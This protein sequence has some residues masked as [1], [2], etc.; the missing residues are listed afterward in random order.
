MK[1]LQISQP[2]DRGTWTIELK[3]DV[4]TYRLNVDSESLVSAS[5]LALSVIEQFIDK[6]LPLELV[7]PQAQRAELAH[8]PDVTFRA[9]ADEV[10][11]TE[12]QRVRQGVL[13]AE[14]LRITENR[15][16]R[17]LKPALGDLPITKVPIPLLLELQ[18][19]LAAKYSTVTVHQYFVIVR[20]VFKRAVELGYT[21]EPPKL[22]EVEVKGGV[23]SPFSAG[24]YSLL[25]RRSKAMIG[26]RH[27]EATPE[28]VKQRGIRHEHLVFMPDTYAAI[29]LMVNSFLRPGDLRTLK[30][31]HVTIARQKD[32]VYLRLTLPPPPKAT[33][34]VVAGAGGEGLTMA[35]TPAKSWSR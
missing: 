6:S 35:Q 9:V 7:S 1:V 12:A 14:S 32:S 22:P 33:L 31:K 24:E 30:H 27:P 18:K 16:D 5:Q 23:R 34:P 17:V 2:D 21:T 8:H 3:T 13:S 25:M 26:A 11:S 20:K 4:K 19:S 28:L 15:I 10:C 29:R